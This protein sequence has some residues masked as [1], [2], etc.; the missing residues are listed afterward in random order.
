MSNDYDAFEDVIGSYHGVFGDTEPGLDPGLKKYETVQAK[1]TQQGVVF[2]LTCQGCGKPTQ[3][4]VEW[5]EMVA[6]KYG[7]N[8]AI[9][10][11]A[12]PAILSNPTRWEWLGV[13]KGDRSP[14]QAWRPEIR[15]RHC[16]FHFP[17]RVSSAEP[18]RFLAAARRAGFINQ[19]GEQQVSQIAAQYAKQGQAV[20][21]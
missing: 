17:L 3:M 11:R 6:L 14:E 13:A 16:D 9:A 20:R 15:C 12:H 7:V 18:E 21:R 8:P 4:L 5:P 19:A 1:P 10:F 2:Q